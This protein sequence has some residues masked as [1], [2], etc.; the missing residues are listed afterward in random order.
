MKTLNR[1]FFIL[2]VASLANISCGNN[3]LNYE[4]PD[5]NLIVSDTE[6]EHTIQVNQ[7]TDFNLSF[8]NA[9]G[10]ISYI[11]TLEGNIISEDDTYTF[12][13]EVSGIYRL[14][15]YAE[16]SLG[17]YTNK[18]FTISVLDAPHVFDTNK[19]IAGYLPSYRENVV[20]WD[21]ITHLIYAFVY[22]NQDGTLNTSAMGDLST[23]ITQAKANNVK[24]LVSVGGASY[25]G[26]DV[27]VF[28][29]LLIDN[30]KR[31]NLVNSINTFVRENELDGIDIDYEELV[32]G[33]ATVDNSETNKLLPFYQELRE[34]LPNTSIISAAVT[35]GYGWAAFHFRDIAASM[36]EELDFISIMSYDNL[37]TWSGSP[38]GDHSSLN[39]AVGALAKY[40]EFGIDSSKLVLAVPFYGRDFKMAT[41]GFAEAVTYSDILT[42][43][44]PSNEELVSGRINRDGYN[45]FFNSQE[46]I[47]QKV[48]HVKNNDYRGITIWEIGQDANDNNLSLQKDILNQFY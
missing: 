44:T 19:V 30:I 24:I 18:T 9:E 11:W 13:Q 16:D 37:G 25:P 39:D 32:G 27:R 14:N 28:T 36:A 48:S 40:E 43:Y 38:L 8:I 7:S 21:K 1:L 47:S 31:A 35:G 17:K 26:K 29:S 15:V 23:Y 45:L 33:G 2:I 20:K 4:S 46:I 5:L 6:F 12:T 22:P 34:T 41:G 3:E 10:N 42:I